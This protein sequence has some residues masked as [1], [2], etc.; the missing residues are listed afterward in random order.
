MS[1][2]ISLRVDSPSRPPDWRWQLAKQRLTV[3]RPVER[4]ESP[5]L[6]RA[7]RLAREVTNATADEWA[8][9]DWCN[10]LKHPDARALIDCWDIH[11]KCNVQYNQRTKRQELE[12]RILSGQPTED[13]AKTM[14][15]TPRTVEL[16]EEVF[17]H[18]KDNYHS[19]SWVLHNVFGPNYHLRLNEQDYELIW[20]G[21]AYYGGPFVLDEMIRKCGMGRASTPTEAL[22]EIIKDQRRLRMLKSG[23]AIRTMAVNGFTAVPLLEYDLRAV[24]EEAKLGQSDTNQLSSDIGKLINMV[25]WSMVHDR[26]ARLFEP[27]V[28]TA[29]SVPGDTNTVDW[30]ETINP[31]DRPKSGAADVKDAA[32][33]RQLP[34]APG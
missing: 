10:S 30:D 7:F 15:L 29:E 34:A 33:V 21:G 5:E 14:L 16:Y 27:R 13:I 25:N 12:A 11:E 28:L 6:I 8:F 20:K 23:T 4:G 3:N 1:A 9:V 22:A 17:F 31:Y 26:G 24:S 19:E 18:V 32:N 2:L